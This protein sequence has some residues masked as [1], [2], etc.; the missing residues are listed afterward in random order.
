MVQYAEIKEVERLIFEFKDT[1]S[2]KIC[3]L[4]AG[5]IDET[6]RFLE[7]YLNILEGWYGDEQYHNKVEEGIEL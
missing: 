4:S 5:D 2:K 1:L 6:V 3:C 7:K